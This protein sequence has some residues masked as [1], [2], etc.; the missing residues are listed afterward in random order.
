[1]HSHLWRV[2]GDHLL[3]N[4]PRAATQPGGESRL[5]KFFARRNLLWNQDC[6]VGNADRAHLRGANVMRTSGIRDQSAQDESAV[7]AECLTALC[8]FGERSLNPTRSFSDERLYFATRTLFAES[9]G[10]DRLKP[11]FW[12]NV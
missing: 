5:Q 12:I 11:A 3:G 6:A 10:D 2:D 4:A 9:R 1:L 7:G 8:Q